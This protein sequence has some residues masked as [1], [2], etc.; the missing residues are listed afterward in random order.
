MIRDLL[1]RLE[2]WVFHPGEQLSRWRRILVTWIRLFIF[3]WRQLVRDKMYQQA[4][5]LAFKTVL[6]LLP[7]LVM[8]FFFF[9]PGGGLENVGERVQG[10]IFQSLN[11]DEL[12]ITT[13]EGPTSRRISVSEE[14][15]K[16]LQRIYENLNVSAI[17]I[18]GFLLLILA[19]TS[20]LRQVD[21]ALNQVWKAPTRRSRWVRL[22]TYWTVITVGPIL[23]GVSFYAAD[24]VTQQFGGAGFFAFVQRVVGVVLPIAASWLVLYLAYQ[25]IPNTAVNR[26]SAAVGALVAAIMLE[27]AKFLFSL[28]VRELVPYSRTYGALALLPIFLIWLHLLWV[29][30]LFGAELAYSIQNVVVL[31]AGGALRGLG[32][33]RGELLSVNLLVLVA[34]RF[35]RGDR[36]FTVSQLAQRLHASEQEVHDL[37]G[38]LADKHYLSPLAGRRERFQIARDPSGIAVSEVLETV[39]GGFAQPLPDAPAGASLARLTGFYERLAAARQTAVGGATLADLLPPADDHDDDAPAVTS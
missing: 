1:R 30:F 17:N 37:V 13:G 35:R 28:Y 2:A 25:L 5:A 36:A 26:H 34:H 8:S 21:E 32:L 16:R 18:V 24:R 4:S 6:S 39:R 33:A 10:F 11:V 29:I 20:L 31:G 3:I 12:E 15:N 27:I 19:S 22:T 23:L 9:R 38:V 14:I 7:L